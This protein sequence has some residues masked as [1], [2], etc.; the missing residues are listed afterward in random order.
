MDPLSTISHVIEGHSIRP[1]RHFF[2][3]F[4]LHRSILWQ[5]PW[6][7][8]LDLDKQSARVICKMIWKPDAITQIWLIQICGVNTIIVNKEEMKMERTNQYYKVSIRYKKVSFRDKNLWIFLES[9]GKKRA[10]LAVSGIWEEVMWA[11]LWHWET[12]AV[13][14]RNVE[15]K[16]SGLI[17]YYVISWDGLCVYGQRSRVWADLSGFETQM[18]HKTPISFKKFSYVKMRYL[19]GNN[20][21]GKKNQCILI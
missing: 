17:C 12:I 10:V 18:G 19:R 6:H 13:L 21:T 1:F 14:Q 5:L 15:W 2:F 11:F 20:W 7:K 3:I 4:W 9:P 8:I 16:F